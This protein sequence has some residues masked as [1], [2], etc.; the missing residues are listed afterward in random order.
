MKEK[1]VIVEC[2]CG[3]SVLRFVKDED[4]Y[5]Y[6][7]SYSSLFYERQESAFSILKKKL[8]FIWFILIGKEFSLYDL[9]ITG[10]EDVDNFKKQMNEFLLD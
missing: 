3:C 8:K 9:V 1:R 2:E 6:V 4:G 10:K 7:E 5:I